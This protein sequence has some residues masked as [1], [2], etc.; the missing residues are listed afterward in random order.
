MF[1]SG[2]P[3]SLNFEMQDYRVILARSSTDHLN[4]LAQEETKMKF[5]I[6]LMERAILL[7]LKRSL[8]RQRK[9]STSLIGGSHLNFI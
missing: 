6:L 9:L 5:S 7:E 8:K 2:K 4:L 1:I 3:G